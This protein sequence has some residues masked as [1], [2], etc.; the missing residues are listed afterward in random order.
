MTST[1]TGGKYRCLKCDGDRFEASSTV[2]I[3]I[4]C[5]HVYPCVSGIPRLLIE[6]RIGHQD[7]I[8]RDRMYD[9]LLGRFYDF[10]MP[11]MLMPAR[12]LQLSWPHWTASGGFMF[13][14]LACIAL[15]VQSVRRGWWLAGTACGAAL[16]CAALLFRAHEY[17]LHLA[18][19]AVPVW[20]SLARR[21]FTPQESFADVHAR[22][23]DALR[24]KGSRL[25]V[26]DISTGTC[27]SLYKHGW[28]TLNADFTAID[29]S[30]TMLV[31]GQ[32]F[33]ANARVPVD[34]VLGDAMNLPFQSDTFDVVL[35]Y[36]AINGLSDPARGLSEMSRVAK[37][38]GSILFLDEQLYA[39]ASPV[40][41]R[42][43]ATVLSSHNV[44]H[45]CPV[46]RLPADLRDVRVSQV[47]QFYYICDATK[48]V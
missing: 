27:A 7:R 20:A 10:V 18:Y 46:D 1:P 14:L 47:Y 3:C 15:L 22:V 34:L 38:G 24:A 17:L 12:P 19:L 25:R 41:R 28:M 6:D 13:V 48:A 31:K 2:W 4:G 11:L 30:E 9:G 16:L 21:R 37:P 39:D 29:L 43:F 26:L 5:R 42:Y 8:L 23:L 33:M 44:V 32:T 40:E 35:S 36:G 45:Q